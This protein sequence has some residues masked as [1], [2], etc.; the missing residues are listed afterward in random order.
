MTESE[1]KKKWCPHVRTFDGR[2]SNPVTVNRDYD[3]EVMPHCKCIAS[4]CM[5]WCVEADADGQEL[6][7]TG[8]CGLAGKV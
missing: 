6:A 5:M 4:D 8:H 7:W 3:G 2:V 1:A